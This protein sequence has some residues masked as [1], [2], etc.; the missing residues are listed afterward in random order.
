MLEIRPAVL[1]RSNRSVRRFRCRSRPASIPRVLSATPDPDNRFRSHVA[2]TSPRP[3]T[4]CACRRQRLSRREKRPRGRESRPGSSAIAVTASV[5]MQHVHAVGVREAVRTRTRGLAA[6]V[7]RSFLSPERTTAVSVQR[8]ERGA[9]SSA[10]AVPVDPAGASAVPSDAVSAGPREQPR[11]TM[12]AST[13]LCPV[14]IAE[15]CER[16]RASAPSRRQ[17]IVR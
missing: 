5:K 9:P 11:Q 13:S 7:P 1:E 2:G 8:I 4:P 12:A 10:S 14:G 15:T 6:G 16:C 17:R 3:R